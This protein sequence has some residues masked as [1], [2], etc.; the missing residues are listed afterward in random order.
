MRADQRQIAAEEPED[1]EPIQPR[2]GLDLADEEIEI[3]R[4][5]LSNGSTGNQRPIVSGQT[6]GAPFPA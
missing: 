4:Q 1:Q 6:D 5:C 2:A 3:Y